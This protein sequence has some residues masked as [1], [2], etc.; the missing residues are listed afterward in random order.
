MK[1]KIAVVCCW[2]F[3]SLPSSVLAKPLTLIL[4]WLINPDQ[5]AV[6][7]AQAQGYFH[8][9]GVEVQIV[10]PTSPDDGAK[11]VAAGQA[12]LAITYQPQWLMQVAAGLPL[13]R[14]ATLIDQPLNCLLASS[15][16]GI[17]QLSDLK[18]KRIGYASQ[19]E[20]RLILQ[21]LL[22]KAGLTLNEVNAINVQYNLVQ[23]LLS[24]RLDAITGAM[25]NVEPLQIRFAGQAV[26]I[27]P[28]ETVLPEYDELIV[29][30]NKKNLTDPRLIKFLFALQQ[31]SLFLEKNPE[32]SWQI[33]VRA[34]PSL[35]N[36]LTHQIWQATLPYLAKNPLLFDRDRYQRFESFMFTHSLN[37]KRV[38]IADYAVNLL[39]N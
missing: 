18:G 31:A 34:N 11:L 2:L 1:K 30:A 21:S 33:W 8:A 24:K 9:A 25:R 32:Q 7:I 5:A 10:V 13:V 17:N 19:S 28:I 22:N 6:F 26:K 3:V 39:D 23:A 14:I 35:A 36:E 16:S 38:T 27:F 29:V 12:D 15:D 37:Q 20:S 4:D